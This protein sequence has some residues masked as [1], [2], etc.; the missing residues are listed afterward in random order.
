MKWN[1]KKNKLLE[2]VTLSFLLMGCS[3][4]K[5]PLFIGDYYETDL[6][7]I[8]CYYDMKDNL[9]PSRSQTCLFGSDVLLGISSRKNHFNVQFSSLDS[10]GY[11]TVYTVEQKDVIPLTNFLNDF[12][13][14]S[15]L[16][17]QE[18]LSKA[19]A[20]NNSSNSKSDIAITSG[21]VNYSYINK[22]PVNNDEKYHNKPVLMYSARV[23]YFGMKLE[24]DWL[25]T[26]EDAK[27]LLDFIHKTANSVF[28]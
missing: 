20:F 4:S 12:I 10:T 23:P 16:P 9:Y 6:K 15:E 21:F 22:G 3:I 11:F 7:E 13:S 24:R 27:K 5:H 19:T 26:K 1:I 14:W 8:A 17:E 25:M 28:E 18:R 2:I